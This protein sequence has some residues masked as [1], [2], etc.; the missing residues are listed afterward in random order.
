[1]DVGDSISGENEESGE[2]Y[3]AASGWNRTHYRLFSSHVGREGATRCLIS[4]D[5]VSSNRSRLI[6][7]HAGL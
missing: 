2:T 4:R 3:V 1:V 7:C 5:T 6:H